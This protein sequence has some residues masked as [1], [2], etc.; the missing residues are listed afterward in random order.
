[1]KTIIAGLAVGSAFAF[2]IAIGGIKMGEAI[3]WLVALAALG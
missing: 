3:A 1:M 2:G